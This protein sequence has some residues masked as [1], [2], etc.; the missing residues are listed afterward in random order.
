MSELGALIRHA[1][2]GKGLSQRDLGKIIGFQNSYI[3]KI[4]L[5]RQRGS[6]L[7][8]VKIAKALDIPLE[9]IAAQFGLNTNPGH[10]FSAEDYRFSKL[11]PKLKAVLLELSE[12]L[13]RHIQ[14]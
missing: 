5:G 3:A 12:K 1:R 14:S 2:Q 9:A 8:L 4:E 6:Y 13:E 7:A 11:P 10:K